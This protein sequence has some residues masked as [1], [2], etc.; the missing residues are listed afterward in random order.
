M[1]Q[2][3]AFP[4]ALLQECSLEEANALLVAWCHK[5]G[6][7]ERPKKGDPGAHVLIHGATPIAVCTTSTLIREGVG[8]GLRDVLT[9]ANTIELSRLCAARRDINRVM[10]RLWRELVFPA[11][12]KPFAISYQDADMHNGNTYRFDGWVRIAYSRAGGTDQRSGR[13][14]RNK[15]IWAWASDP[16]GRAYLRELASDVAR[17]LVA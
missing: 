14:G 8:G 2:P 17:E 5:M 6:P 13:P 9:R 1:I 11:L 10:L 12:M 7:L 16:E 4:I 3:T 15:W